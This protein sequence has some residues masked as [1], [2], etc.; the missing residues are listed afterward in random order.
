MAFQ[1]NT[2]MLFRRINRCGR[3]FLIAAVEAVMWL[4]PL[5]DRLL[6][7]MFRAGHH[8]VIYLF[9]QCFSGEGKRIPFVYFLSGIAVLLTV[10]DE[11]LTY[12]AKM[13]VT[14]CGGRAY[15]RSWAA[16]LITTAASITFAGLMAALLVVGLIGLKAHAPF[17]DAAA[18]HY[19][20]F[21]QAP[22]LGILF[23]CLFFSFGSGLFCAVSCLVLLAS[24]DLFVA[25]ILP[26]A[27][28]YGLNYLSAAILHVPLTSYATGFYRSNFVQSLLVYLPVV[29]SLFGLT[30]MGDI[31][32]MEKRIGN[33]LGTALSRR[34]KR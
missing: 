2:H 33:E 15:E 3:A 17:F 16:V 24:G 14:R 7:E 13:A 32:L 31:A 28:F 20:P 19:A 18:D 30:V 6:M 21:P 29:V 10:Y 4:Y 34:K 22:F 26:A 25:L 9:E 5:R 11:F 27:L 23:R 12:Y 8:S 1:G